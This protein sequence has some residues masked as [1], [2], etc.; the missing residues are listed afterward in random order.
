MNTCPRAL[1]KGNYRT[2]HALVQVELY[3]AIFRFTGVP[4]DVGGEGGVAVWGTAGEGERLSQLKPK[5]EGMRGESLG[6][7]F[8]DLDSNLH[9]PKGR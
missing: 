6:F 2:V 8:Q 4:S 7:S 9:L 1:S 5:P 3:T